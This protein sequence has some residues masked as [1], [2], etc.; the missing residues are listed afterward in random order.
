MSRLNYSPWALTCCLATLLIGVKQVDAQELQSS[1]IS[2]STSIA[3]DD[4]ESAKQRQALTADDVDRKLEEVVADAGFRFDDELWIDIESEL[5]KTLGISIELSPSVEDDLAPDD[6]VSFAIE[7]VSYRVALNR[8]LATKNAAFVVQQGL[9]VIISR[10]DIEDPQYRRTMIIDCRQLLDSIQAAEEAY[11]TATV[12][13]NRALPERGTSSL[14]SRASGRT[15]SQRLAE[16]VRASVDQEVWRDSGNGLGSFE[17]I[18]GRCVVTADEFTLDQ[19]TD[20]IN[21]LKQVFQESH[22]S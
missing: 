13:L 17:M 11:P 7:S 19:V 4:S 20:M 16:V 14:V 8:L 3:G 12:D 15:A 9:L 22:G 5:E 2:V 6:A 18:G 1:S 21:R 10:D